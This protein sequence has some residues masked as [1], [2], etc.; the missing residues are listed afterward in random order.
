MLIKSLLTLLLFLSFSFSPS[1]LHFRLKESQK[2][3]HRDI[4]IMLLLSMKL[5]AFSEEILSYLE[6]KR[7]EWHWVGY[8]F[9]S[10]LAFFQLTLSTIIEDMIRY[11]SLSSLDPG[12]CQRVLSKNY[13]ILISMAPV[14]FECKS[15]RVACPV[16]VGPP[17]PEVGQASKQKSK[18]SKKKGKQIRSNLILS[19]HPGQF[20]LVQNVCLST[21]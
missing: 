16:H 9:S 7:V 18:K 6:M 12:T 1:P 19:H 21:G 20:S 8:L 17:I 15:L 5:F 4:L 3:T 10:F 11:E 14:S 2:G 13:E